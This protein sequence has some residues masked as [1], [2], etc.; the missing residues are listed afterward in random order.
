MPDASQAPQI[1]FRVD[2]CPKSG[3]WQLRRCLALAAGLK[4]SEPSCSISFFSRTR[5]PSAI[6]GAGCDYVPFGELSLP[7]W[8]LEATVEKAE[9]LS[10]DMLVVDRQTADA[11]FIRS[12]GAKVRVLAVFGDTVHLRSYAAHAIIDPN[13]HAHLLEYPSEGALFLGTEFAL[14]P[15]EFDTFQDFHCANPERTRR[16]LVYSGGPDYSVEAVRLL[17]PVRC[18]FSATM[19]TDVGPEYGE[20]L[21]REIGLDPRFMVLRNDGGIAKRLASC[22]FVI[23]GPETLCEPALFSL[24][25]ALIGESPVSDYAAKNGLAL[26]LGAADCLDAQSA[27][28][29]EALLSDKMARDR[30]SARLGGLVDGL[31]RFRLADELLRLY[32]NEGA[33]SE[34]GA[35]GRPDVRGAGSGGCMQ[36]FGSQDDEGE[37]QLI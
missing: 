31:G 2:S 30:M 8:D 14:L 15:S 35:G 32:R 3:S 5:D 19:L 22:D 7:S 34:Q 20:E 29:L 13:I 17:K 18:Q 25:V 24:P 28:S 21:A 12:L 23:T 37:N 9:S 4:E 36:A 11:D 26:S 16:I 33:V 27:V 1:A 6:T 10:I